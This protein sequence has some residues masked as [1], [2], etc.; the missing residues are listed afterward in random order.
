[1]PYRV[2]LLVC[3]PAWGNVDYATSWAEQLQSMLGYIVS[4]NVEV[5]GIKKQAAR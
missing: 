5:E 1:M 3:L 2:L 4:M